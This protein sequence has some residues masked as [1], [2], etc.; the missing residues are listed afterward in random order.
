MKKGQ[1]P[2]G[3]L[4]V[5]PRL[6]RLAFYADKDV[7]MIPSNIKYTELRQFL[8]LNKINTLIIDERTIN[9][10]I[11]GFNENIGMLNV[12]KVQIPELSALKQY[13]I[14]V[15]EIERNN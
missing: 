8:D 2:V 10:S 1:Y 3:K 12:R 5:E 7:I 13:S 9:E 11:C 15:F 4:A 14:T 6:S